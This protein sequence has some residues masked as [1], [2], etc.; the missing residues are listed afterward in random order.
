ME[1]II[2]L[3]NPLLWSKYILAKSENGIINSL[4]L[5]DADPQRLRLIMNWSN[6]GACVNF[7]GVEKRTIKS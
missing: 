6:I 1:K 7:S 2:V 4:T 3:G 5:M